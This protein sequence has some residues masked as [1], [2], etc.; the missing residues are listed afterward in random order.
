MGSGPILCFTV[1]N[2]NKYLGRFF[3]TLLLTKW[4]SVPS[5]PY[6]LTTPRKEVH[7]DLKVHC[8]TS[9]AIKTPGKSLLWQRHNQRKTHVDAF[10]SLRNPE[11]HFS[12]FFKFSLYCWLC[13]GAEVWTLGLMH[14]NY[15]HHHRATPSVHCLCLKSTLYK[16]LC[17][18]FLLSTNDEVSYTTWD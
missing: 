10:F 2:R 4:A 13:F 3:E 8:C 9:Q 18:L 12:F 6:I 7:M 11:K 16:N 1:L 17:V 15:V 14:I 5:L